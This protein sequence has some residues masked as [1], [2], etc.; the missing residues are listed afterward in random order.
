MQHPDSYSLWLNN[1]VSRRFKLFLQ[2][3]LDNRL[4]QWYRSPQAMSDTQ[5]AYNQGYARAVSDVL[6]ILEEPE[7]FAKKMS[8]TT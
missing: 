1:D 5:A 8:N 4:A 7:Q 3:T 6:L 2:A